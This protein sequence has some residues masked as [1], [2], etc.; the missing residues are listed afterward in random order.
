MKTIKFIIQTTIVTVLS[1]IT[2]FLIIVGVTCFI[3]STKQDE[4]DPPT[5][6]VEST[7]ST[8]TTESQQKSFTESP[9]QPERK[10]NISDIK[11]ARALMSHP[12]SKITD[13][14]VLNDYDGVIKTATDN[15]NNGVGNKEDYELYNIWE[16]MQEYEQTNNK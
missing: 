16:D 14:H 4:V 11:Y 7:Q 1:F 2:I 8:S 13:I 5:E 12:R 10:P 9:V 3:D 6:K 15:I